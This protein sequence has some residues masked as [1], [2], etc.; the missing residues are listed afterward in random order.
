MDRVT[1]TSL[2]LLSLLMD[3]CAICR[4][5]QE[6][7]RWEEETDVLKGEKTAS[8]LFE[9]DIHVLLWFTNLSVSVC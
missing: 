7:E 1:E 4:L 8:L 9:D 2:S 5:L 3:V 6:Q